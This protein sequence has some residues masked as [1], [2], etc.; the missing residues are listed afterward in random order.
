MP[1]SGIEITL[2]YH[3]A[4]RKKAA[5]FLTSFNCCPP[6]AEEGCGGYHFKMMSKDEVMFLRLNLDFFAFQKEKRIF[7]AVNLNKR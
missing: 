3:G 5:A 1:H 2:Q 7:A 4:K 6:S